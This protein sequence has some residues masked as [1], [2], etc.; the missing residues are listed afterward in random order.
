VSYESYRRIASGVHTVE[1][2]RTTQE[3]Y[4]VLFGIFSQEDPILSTLARD[5][6]FSRSARFV[7]SVV[8]PYIN[9]GISMED[10]ILHGMVGLDVAIS[11]YDI[12]LGWK[13]TTYAQIRVAKSVRDALQEASLLATPAYRHE[14][15]F[16][17]RREMG[18]GDYAGI[19]YQ[20]QV[21]KLAVALEI[22]TR[23]V[24]QVL[25]LLS[26]TSTDFESLEQVLDGEGF[27]ESSHTSELTPEESYCLDLFYGINE[28]PGKRWNIIKI[29]RVLHHSVEEVSQILESGKR[30]IQI[31]LE[32]G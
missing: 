28:H 11:R 22:H 20:E 18:R 6:I 19:S 29:A 17:V 8:K 5:L 30:K 24:I 16:R 21:E 32:M 4:R 14:Q 1:D 12:S 10:L 27:T 26:V 9:K 23:D 13:F 2:L 7:I 31:S 3:E 15:M 25:Y